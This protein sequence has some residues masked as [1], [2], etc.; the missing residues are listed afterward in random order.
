MVSLLL[1]GTALDWYVRSVLIDVKNDWTRL[2]QTLLTQFQ[3][4][5]TPKAIWKNIR[6]VRQGCE[7]DIRDFI[8]RFE[9]LHRRLERLGNDQVPP[10]FMKRDQL[11]GACLHTCRDRK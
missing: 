5:E 7:E 4:T 6:R 8:R 3:K 11:I 10:D 9:N 1:D 2:Q